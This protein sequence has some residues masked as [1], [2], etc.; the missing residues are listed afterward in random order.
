ML[1]SD[2]PP[3][4]RTPSSHHEHTSPSSP[5]FQESKETGMGSIGFLFRAVYF[6]RNKRESQLLPG[7]FVGGGGVS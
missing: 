7:F 6:A 4:D 1:D 3:N 2:D 5:T